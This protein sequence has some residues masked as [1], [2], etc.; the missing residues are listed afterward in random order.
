MTTFYLRR[1]DENVLDEDQSLVYYFLS[2]AR[3]YFAK[4]WPRVNNGEMEDQLV[5]QVLF[6]NWVSSPDGQTGPPWEERSRNQTFVKPRGSDFIVL[7]H[8]F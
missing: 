3:S 1:L 7:Y 2:F 5:V 4:V 6:H 8:S